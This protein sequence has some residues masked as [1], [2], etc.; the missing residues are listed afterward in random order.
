M[1]DIKEL[2]KWKDTS[3]QWDRKTQNSKEISSSHLDLY[4]FSVISVPAS[5]FEDIDKLILTFRWRDK[6]PRIT[7]TVLK[8]KV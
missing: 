8:S 5:Y 4:K 6:T 7:N 1:K 2:N 3:Y